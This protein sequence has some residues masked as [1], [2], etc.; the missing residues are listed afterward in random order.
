[1]T[2]KV[3]FLRPLGLRLGYRYVMVNAYVYDGIDFS[4]SKHTSLALQHVTNKGKVSF[5]DNHEDTI[6]DTP[7]ETTNSQ[8]TWL[9]IV[10]ESREVIIVNIPF[11]T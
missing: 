6:I 9:F 8:Y 2:I 1:M 5:G 7:I 11:Y 3:V 4:S 10:L